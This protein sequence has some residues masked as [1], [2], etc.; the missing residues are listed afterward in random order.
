MSDRGAGVAHALRLDPERA[1]TP[2]GA[3]RAT[4]REEC[5]RAAGVPRCRH[6]CHTG[7]RLGVH[8]GLSGVPGGC[9]AGN[10]NIRR[11]PSGPP[12]L[13]QLRV[14]SGLLDTMGDSGVFSLRAAGLL[15][16]GAAPFRVGGMTWKNAPATLS[17]G[18][19]HFMERGG[20]SKY[21]AHP[22]TSC[23][24]GF[25][26]PRKNLP[27]APHSNRAECGPEPGPLAGRSTARH[28]GQGIGTGAGFMA[29]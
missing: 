19:G 18:E 2:L 10:C 7:A 27:H 16:A 13:D 20:R 11:W 8:N 12:A 22:P 25:G 3:A 15:R 29:G 9:A 14:S 17:V 1:G 6:H 21:R 23:H 5:T 4:S 26:N 28:W 24:R